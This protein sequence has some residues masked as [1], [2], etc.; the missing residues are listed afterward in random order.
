MTTLEVAMQ[1]QHAR[2]VST[3]GIQAG[4]LPVNETGIA[5]DDI[6]S[7]GHD[8]ITELRRNS[9]DDLGHVL[10]HRH[11]VLSVFA[12]GGMEMSSDR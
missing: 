6:Q 5:G 4:Q 11:N 8:E 2:P 3:P 9:R 10:G 12:G 7:S 1:L